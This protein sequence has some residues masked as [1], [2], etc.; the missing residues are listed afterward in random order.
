LD[1]LERIGNAML[2]EQPQQVGGILVYD[3]ILARDVY[4]KTVRGEVFLV[5][6]RNY[7]QLR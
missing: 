6:E 1:V 4:A 2:L 5:L 3:H 7:Q